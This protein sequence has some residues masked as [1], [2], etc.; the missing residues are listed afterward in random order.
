MLLLLID[1]IPNAGS[2]FAGVG[3]IARLDDEVLLH[4]EEGAVIIV[5][6]L[7]QLQEVLAEQRTPFDYRLKHLAACMPRCV[8][9]SSPSRSNTMS[10][11]LVSNKTDMLAV[12]GVTQVRDRAVKRVGY[13][14]GRRHKYTKCSFSLV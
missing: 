1:V 3:W 12:V 14:V 10:P 9:P 5:V 8:G 11:I 7:A 2:S 6:D 4:I 13:R